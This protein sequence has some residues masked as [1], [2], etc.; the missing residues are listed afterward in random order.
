[1]I[2]LVYYGAGGEASSYTPPATTNSK[3]GRTLR[4]GRHRGLLFSLLL[5]VIHGTLG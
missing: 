4:H 5:W 2:P 1:M 3:F